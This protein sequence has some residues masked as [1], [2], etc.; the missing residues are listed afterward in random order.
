MVRLV[1]V[2]SGQTILP[3]LNPKLG[4]YA[5]R[6]LGRRGVQLRLGTR[7]TGV[8][9]EGVALSDGT[10]IP[11]RTVVWAAGTAPSPMLADLPCAKQGGRVVADECLRVAEW[12]GVWALGDCARI[13]DGQGG[14]YPPTAPHA[15]RQGM[16]LGR[17][18]A[19]AI[20]G[21]APRPFVFSAL[22][23]LASI[24][25]RT[26]VANILGASFSGFLAW[27]MWRSIYL[28]K[29]PGLD[30][31]VRVALDW[32]LDLLLEKDLVQ[33]QAER[34]GQGEREAVA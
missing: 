19:A 18:L 10:V 3:E 31:K 7:V 30:R 11:A 4:V 5:A 20:R 23:Q 21:E 34:S 13:P 12:P 2:H 24:G 33:L 14:W 9:D 16:V 22:G 1:V 6:V 15:L 32:T 29:L 8:S 27:W 26:G 28:S 17:N 25:R